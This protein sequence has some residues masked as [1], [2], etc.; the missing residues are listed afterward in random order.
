ML[1]RTKIVA[2]FGPASSSLDV[3]RRLARC[4][5]DVF[6]INFSH[7]TPEEHAR[8]LELIRQVEAEVGQC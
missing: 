7:G 3:V 4:G 5:C 6:R 2:T 1:I 8:R